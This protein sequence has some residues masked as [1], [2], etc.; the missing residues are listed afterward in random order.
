M[1]PH[2]ARALPITPQKPPL[3]DKE[4]WLRTL[5]RLPPVVFL[6]WWPKQSQPCQNVNATGSSLRQWR[7][8]SGCKILQWLWL[9]QNKPPRCVLPPS[10]PHPDRA[11]SSTITARL[12]YLPFPVLPPHSYAV[13]AWGHGS[14]PT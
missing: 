2:I 12:G 10:I 1:Y 5:T 13:H 8:W 6:F 7:T 3:Q 11:Q 4:S 14:P 9:V